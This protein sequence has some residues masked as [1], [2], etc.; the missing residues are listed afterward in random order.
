MSSGTWDSP[1]YITGR[2]LSP[3]DTPQTLLNRIGPRYFETLGIP[4]LRGR[5]IGAQDTASAQKAVVINQAL[6]DR[7]F[8]KGDALGQTFRVGDPD[9]QGTWQIVGIVGNAKF[10]NP[11][12]K[13]QPMAYLAVMQL[14]GDAQ[15][16]YCIQV[17]TAGDPS[18]VGPEVRT[19]FAAIDPNLPIQQMQTMTEAMDTLIDVP[20][21]VSQLSGFFAALALSLACIGLYGVL[22]YNVVHRTSEIGLR[23]ALGA[24]RPSVHWLI[25]RES[26]LL[27]GIGL[28]LGILAGLGATRLLRS[29]LFGINPSDPLTL[30]CAVALLTIVVLAAAWLPARR[31]SR[32]D[33][34]VALRYE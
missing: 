11:A 17:Q 23:M 33:P 7:Y 26:L 6:A 30:A 16:A 2:P 27:L 25:L 5:T 10:N 3:T 32:V 13:P 14:T 22:S 24:G 4:L 31:A 1:I 15:Y 18:L 28:L 29:A 21:L 34:I 19:A 12:E 8:P 20:I 9:V